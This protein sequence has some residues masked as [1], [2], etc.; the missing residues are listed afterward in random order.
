MFLTDTNNE[1][2]EPPHPLEIVFSK[3]TKSSVLVTM[4]IMV[5]IIK[6]FLRITLEMRIILFF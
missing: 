6:I 2:V 4:L 1:I 5:V 3:K